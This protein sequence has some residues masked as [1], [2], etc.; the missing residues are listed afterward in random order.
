[1]VS[2]SCVL[3]SLL[4]VFCF[5]L[6]LGSLS[7]PQIAAAN[8]NATLSPMWVITD[9]V[10]LG[11]LDVNQDYSHEYYSDDEEMAGSVA[12]SLQAVSSGQGRSRVV[13]VLSVTGEEQFRSG[14]HISYGYGSSAGG[15]L[16]GKEI[17]G[18]IMCGCEHGCKQGNLDLNMAAGYEIVKFTQGMAHSNMRADPV[19]APKASYNL[20][21]SSANAE[22]EMKSG[23][24]VTSFSGNSSQNYEQHITVKGSFNFY[25]RAEVN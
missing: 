7:I 21:A 18:T 10:S 19:A 4:L 9:I 8:G 2:K 14:S 12:H 5:V 3:D 1:M 22:G 23:V 24:A 15:E 20:F 16:S 25:H 13:N 17:M 6:V 11:P